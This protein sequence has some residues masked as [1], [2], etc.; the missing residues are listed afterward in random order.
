M[1]CGVTSSVALRPRR[2]SARRRKGLDDDALRRVPDQH[3]IVRGKTLAARLFP[4]ALSNGIDF[5]VA[6]WIFDTANAIVLIPSS[7]AGG[8]G[9]EEMT[10]DR[11]ASWCRIRRPSPFCRGRRRP[12]G[13]SATW[14]FR[15]G[16]H[17]RSTLEESSRKLSARPGPAGFTYV[18]GLEVEWYLT[19]HGRQRA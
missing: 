17:F 15:M 12:A 11:T 2:S 5:P 9:M 19:R 7:K 10:G 8:F 18:T 3:G 4:Q 1:V 13:S 14:S 16:S 6:P